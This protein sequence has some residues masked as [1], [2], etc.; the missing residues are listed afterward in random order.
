VQEL[1]SGTKANQLSVARGIDVLNKAL[2]A[3]P[4]LE[5]EFHEL[6]YVRDSIIHHNSTTKEWE[7]QGKKRRVSPLFI[8]SQRTADTDDKYLEVSEQQLKDATGKVIQQL[9]WYYEQ[10][11]VKKP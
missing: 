10:L 1:P 6:V 9:K 4:V 7:F 3:G 2:G 11:R 8:G 5:T